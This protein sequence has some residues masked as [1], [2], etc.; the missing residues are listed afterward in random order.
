M[1]Q[2]E[3]GNWP[4]TL[5]H[6]GEN[7]WCGTW[8]YVES[9]ADVDLDHSS[10]AQLWW[11]SLGTAL[12]FFLQYHTWFGFLTIQ[13]QLSARE[14]SIFLSFAICKHRP[15]ME[16]MELAPTIGWFHSCWTRWK[17]LASG[18]ISTTEAA[19]EVVSPCFDEL[20]SVAW[21]RRCGI[22]HDFTWFYC[23]SEKT[24]QLWPCSGKFRMEVSIAMGV[25]Q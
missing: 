1:D 17:I 15:H 9:P 10:F 24:N 12:L 21:H 11:D 7:F 25:P 8:W 5:I 18:I 4:Q 20:Q 19:Q 2:L 23:G 14:V 3:M 16:Y 22:L 6:F 13:S